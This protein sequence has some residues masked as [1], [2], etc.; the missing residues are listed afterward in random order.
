MINAGWG[1][2]IDFHYTVVGWRR[3]ALHIPLMNCLRL[4][5]VFGPFKHRCVM[6]EFHRRTDENCSQ[7]SQQARMRTGSH[8]GTRICLVEDLI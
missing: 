5:D 2:H 8:A 7:M 1:Q 4:K 3:D 6:L